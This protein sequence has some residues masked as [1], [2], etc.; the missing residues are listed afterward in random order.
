VNNE[1]T[2]AGVVSLRDLLMRRIS[3]KEASLQ[4]LEALATAGGPG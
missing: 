2:V 3:E 1:N 4:T